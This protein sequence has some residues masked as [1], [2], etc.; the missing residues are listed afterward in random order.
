MEKLLDDVKNSYYA[1]LDDSTHD[2]N[3]IQRFLEKNN[4]L[5][6]LPFLCGHYLHFDA[7]ISKFKLGNEHVTDFAYLTKCSDY[8]ELV[9]I[10]LEDSKKKL[11]NQDREN[12]YFSAD[13]NHAYDQITS[14][15]AYIDENRDSILKKIEKIRVPLGENPIHFKYVLI[16]GRNQDKQGSEKK[17]RMFAQKSDADTKVMTYDSVISFCE[18][19]PYVVGKLILTPWKDQGYRV[20]VVPENLGTSIFAYVSPEYLKI[21][22]ENIEKLKQQDYQIDSWLNGNMLIINDKYDKETF[23]NMI[24]N[25]LYKA[26]CEIDD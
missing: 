4:E 14:W 20:K 1:L 17:T 7:V 26:V 3:D 21:D 5:I 15:K 10:E 11:F 23:K 13:F 9:L 12:I 16:I 22:E 18:H 8:W 2:E 25:P 24:K 6:P 19:L